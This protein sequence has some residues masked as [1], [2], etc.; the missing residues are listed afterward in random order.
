MPHLD[1]SRGYP[2]P[3]LVRDGW[4]SLNGRWDFAIDFDGGIDDPAAVAWDASIVVPFAP[5]TAA[6]GIGNTDL[7]R[8]DVVSAHVRGPGRARP[9]GT[10][11]LRRGGLRRH[12]LGKRTPRW[13]A[14]GR[15]HAVRLRHHP[16]RRRPLDVPARRSGGRRSGRSREAARQARLAARSAL[17]LVSAHV[18]HLADGLARA[19]A[20]DVDRADPLDAESRALGDRLQRLVRRTPGRRAAAPRHADRWRDRSSPTTSTRSPTATRTAASRCPIPASTTRATS[21]CGVPARPQLIEAELRLEGPG[22]KVVDRVRSYTALRAIAVDG[23]R[24]I[25]N[26]RPCPLRLVLD[27]GYWP[28]SGLDRAGRRGAAPRR[29]AGQGDGVQRRSQTPEDRGSPLPVL[30]RSLG[31]AGVGGDAQRLSL[32]DRLHPAHDPG[33]DGRRSGETRAIRA[34]SRGSRS[35]NPGACP[36]CPTTPPSATTSAGSTT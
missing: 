32:H 33:V 22:G 30:G 21:C 14:R 36:T 23:N 28:E 16:R 26:G 4:M 19:R 15:L 18:G 10:P 17:D 35:T 7:Y 5:E 8:R 1:Q 3:Q 34:S 27:Q 12:S 11:A 2:R 20:R 6:S 24:L 13:D 25:L 29:R 9:L 31:A